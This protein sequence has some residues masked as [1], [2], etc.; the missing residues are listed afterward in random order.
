MSTDR[1]Q[2]LVRLVVK[3]RDDSA[4]SGDR[5]TERDAFPSPCPADSD[6]IVDEGCGPRGEMAAPSFMILV[7]RPR[8]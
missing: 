3:A 2:R 7:V 4:Y 1:I 6:V 8:R 5:E